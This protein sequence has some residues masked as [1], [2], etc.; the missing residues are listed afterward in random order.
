[1]EN[2]SD[3][4]NLFESVVIKLQAHAKYIIPR[5]KNEEERIQ[6]EISFNTIIEHIIRTNEPVEPKDIRHLYYIISNRKV[7]D[8]VLDTYEDIYFN[9]FKRFYGR[10]EDF[11]LEKM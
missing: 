7:H 5:I 8:N 10:S 6:A 11:Y 1:M 4:S 9:M 2:N 3:K